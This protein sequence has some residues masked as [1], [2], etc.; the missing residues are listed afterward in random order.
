MERLMRKTDDLIIGGGPGGYEVAAELAASGRR[1][2]LV[3]RAELG[4]TCLN[5][6][7][8]P[9]KCLCATA[10]LALNIRRGPEFGVNTGPV[11]VD[12]E[13]ATARMRG[14]VEQLREGI[15]AMLSSVEVIHGEASVTAEGHVAVNG[16]IIAAERILIATGSRPSRLQIDGAELA[17]TSDDILRDQ[18]VLPE[19]L[20]IIG[21]G[22]IGIEFASIYN[23]LG[24]E[25]TVV[26][27]CKEILPQFDA[28]VAKRLRLALQSRG[29]KFVTAACVKKIVAGYS[30]HYSTKRGDGCADAD[31]V[32]M[33]TGRQPVL[34]AGIEEAGIR[35]TDKGF[36]AVDDEMRTSRSG[37]FAA[38]D[39]TGMCMLAHAAE[40]QARIAMKC[41]TRKPD[42]NV[43]PSAVFSVPEAAMAGLTAAEC[44]R[45]GI[46]CATART[47]YAANGKALSEGVAQT[48]LLKIV[49]SPDNRRILG[50]HALGAHASDLVAEGAAL[51]CCDAGLDVLA[52]KIVH[53]HP[54]LSELLP[55]AA[56]SAKSPV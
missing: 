22:V 1:V 13:V 9:T 33:A 47:N 21:G 20:I 4:G 50:I 55:A 54:T 34:P 36:I 14:V 27:Y 42:L 7:C 11:S 53:N 2:V 51:M 19:R 46:A 3:E 39:V 35:L 41:G 6:G 44:E 49:Y 26:E 8:I 23:A 31:M 10:Q 52:D 32:L 17:A 48:G 16:E 29:V 25:V 24:V 56:R 43:I 12:F 37:F 30:V 45:R 18:T 38:G 5:R 40:A 15:G 28:D